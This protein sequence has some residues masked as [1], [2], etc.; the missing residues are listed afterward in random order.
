MSLNFRPV[1]NAS[2]WLASVRFSFHHALV[3]FGSRPT[4]SAIL[5]NVLIREDG[6]WSPLILKNFIGE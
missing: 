2:S 5:L 4:N 1:H 3:L 6:S